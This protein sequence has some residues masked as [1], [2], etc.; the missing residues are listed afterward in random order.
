MAYNAARLRLRETTVRRLMLAGGIAGPVLFSLA[1]IIFGALRPGY[2]PVDQFISELGETG[3]LHAPLMNV[4]GFMGG[5]AMMLL[6]AIALWQSLPRSALTTIGSL[7]IA[8]F[9]VN[10]FGAGVWSCDVG[11]PT[12]NGS[13]EQRMHDLVSVIA[14]P[15]LILGALTWSIWF[16]RRPEWRAFGVYSL[17][18]GLAAI[19]LLV[20]MI[21]SEATRESTGLLQRLFLLV[22]FVWMASLAYRLLR[23]NPALP[24]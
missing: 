19:G 5:G 15:A 2:D 8:V 17:I 14:F 24:A 11:C 4:L 1:S 10:V 20:A 12:S 3:G 13:P 22:L 6:F 23:R 18:T 16:L 21:A 7:L 9:A